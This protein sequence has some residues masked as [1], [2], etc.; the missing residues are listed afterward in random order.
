MGE[1]QQNINGFSG[2][3]YKSFDTQEEAEQFLR[4]DV[5]SGKETDSVKKEYILIEAVAYVDGSYNQQ[6]E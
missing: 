5:G 1:C 6:I 3:V 4:G 2:S